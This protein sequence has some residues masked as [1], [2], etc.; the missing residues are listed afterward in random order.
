MSMLTRDHLGD[1]RYLSELGLPQHIAWSGQQIAQSL[2]QTLA[3]R[4]D[5][6]PIWVLAYGSLMWNPLIAFEAEH[7]ATLHGWHRS[8]CLRSIG[9]RGSP[10]HPGRVLSLQPGGHVHGVALRLAEQTAHAELHLLWTREMPTGAYHPVWVPLTL[11][12]GSTATAITFVANTEHTLHEPDDSPVTVARLIAVAAGA[13]GQNMDYV[14][15][16]HQALKDRGQSDS[17]ISDV[18]ACIE[19]LKHHPSCD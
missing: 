13:F 17:Y 11:D 10:Q 14:R 19:A 3:A 18:W 9:G 12:N 8:F 2:A 6:G 4:P 1:G 7:Q 16:L 15:A 5:R